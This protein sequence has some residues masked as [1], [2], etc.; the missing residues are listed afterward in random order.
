MAYN[1]IHHEASGQKK[2]KCV[3]PMRILFLKKY[4]NKAFLHLSR[5]NYK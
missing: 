4:D 3:P 5:V 1:S 2:G